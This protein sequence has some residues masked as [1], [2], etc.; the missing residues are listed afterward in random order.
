MS[1]QNTS[2]YI[3]LVIANL[4]PLHVVRELPHPVRWTLRTLTYRQ[5]PD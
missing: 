4:I 2:E 5:L 3:P 1:P